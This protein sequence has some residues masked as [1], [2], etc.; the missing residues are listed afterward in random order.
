MPIYAYW[1]QWLLKKKKSYVTKNVQI[2]KFG[3]VKA[4]EK[5]EEKKNKR[6]VKRDPISPIL[7]RKS[8]CLIVTPS[9]CTM[10]KLGPPLLTSTSYM[11]PCSAKILSWNH[12]ECWKTYTGMSSTSSFSFFFLSF[13]LLSIFLFTVTY[14]LHEKY[15]YIHFLFFLKRPIL[16]IMSYFLKDISY[17]N[18]VLRLPLRF[19]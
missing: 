7:K 8:D 12:S 2:S 18:I 5:S 9:W 11:V 10:E 6:N 19:S 16:K 17:F 13:H 1:I 14:P 3:L 15:L 4:V